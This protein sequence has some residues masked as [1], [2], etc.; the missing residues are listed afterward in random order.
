MTTQETADRRH[1]QGI[2]KD[3]HRA[4]IS[5]NTNQPDLYGLIRADQAL[6]ERLVI[7]MF[8]PNIGVNW[9]DFSREF[10]LDKRSRLNDLA[11][12]IYSYFLNDYQIVSNF[13]PRYFGKDK[14]EIINKLESSSKSSLDSWFSEFRNQD[15][16]QEGLG[17]FDYPVSIMSWS[18]VKYV[19]FRRKEG[20]E[21]YT[22]YQRQNPRGVIFKYEFWLK[23]SIEKGF[24]EVKTSSNRLLRIQYA[25]F[26]ELMSV[27]D[28]TLVDEPDDETT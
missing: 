3:Q 25:S 20:Y 23:F 1:Y 18:G 22:Q 11:Y 10:F 8:K 6:I 17:E 21:H 13:N 26:M 2:K 14:F 19:C 4:I 16:K 28:E 24:A 5:L 7:L 9:S 15:F 12:T 27:D